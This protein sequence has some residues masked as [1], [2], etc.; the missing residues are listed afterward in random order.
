[1]AQPIS[2][3]SHKYKDNERNY[4]YQISIAM[5]LPKQKDPSVKESLIR[6]KKKGILY[7][8][9]LSRICRKKNLDGALKLIAGLEGE[10]KYNIYG[11]LEDLS[12]WKV[13]QKII[14]NLPRNITVNYCGEVP[15]EQ[16]ENVFSEHDLF[17]FPTHGENYGHVIMEALSAGCPVLISNQTPWRNLE[18]IGVGW[19]VDLGDTDRIRAILQRCV[20]M[21]AEEH[22][23]LSRRA[24]AYGM[25]RSIDPDILEQNR[26]LFRITGLRNK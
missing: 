23:K 21:G 19:D 5:D 18:S 12:Y 2:N 17:F 6:D 20:D 14:D 13:C 11:P 4:N 15:H 3:I 7:M 24:L 1:M 16:V 10:I 8:I 9:F 25:E 26:K 22:K